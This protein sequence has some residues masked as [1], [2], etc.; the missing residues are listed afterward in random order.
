MPIINKLPANAGKTRLMNQIAA[1]VNRIAANLKAE[2]YVE[3]PR[4]LR[5]SRQ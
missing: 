3:N 4:V 5:S 2:G 1:A